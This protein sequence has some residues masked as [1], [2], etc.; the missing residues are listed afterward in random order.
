[1]GEKLL[2]YTHYRHVVIFFIITLFLPLFGYITDISAANVVAYID[3]TGQ[4]ATAPSTVNSPPEVNISTAQEFFISYVTSSSEFG[5]TDTIDI[6]LPA[7]FTSLTTCTSSTTNADGDATDPDG[8]VNVASQ[9]FTYTF[10][11][12]TTLANT[13]GVEICFKATTPGTAGNYSVSI[14]DDNDTDVSAAL[15]YVGGGNDLTVTAD[16]GVN[17]QLA[18]KDPS[19]TADTNSCALGTLNPAATNT[20]S[21]RIA[22]GT[23]FGGGIEVY[24][25]ADDQLNTSVATTDVDDIADNTL[26]AGTEEHGIIVTDGTDFTVQAPFHASNYEEINTTADAES[27]EMIL[28]AG[29]AT[30]SSNTANWSTIEH[31]ASINTGTSTGTYDQEVTYRAFAGT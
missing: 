23:S 30:D 16:V 11:A 5:I 13:T 19:T 22:A 3:L 10:T 15:I 6:T 26:D 27:A 2:K 14:S 21:Y 24:I 20:C 4:P 9:T 8:A 1:M 28:D 29:S 12:V 31:G 18:I 25:I 7:S 17:L